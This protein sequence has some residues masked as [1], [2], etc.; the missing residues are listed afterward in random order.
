MSDGGF[1]L[2][3]AAVASLFDA[4]TLVV[5]EVAPRSGGLALPAD[6]AIVGLKSPKGADGSRKLSTMAGLGYYLKVISREVR[7]ADVVH[8]PLPGDISLLGFVVALAFRKR[9]IGRYGSSWVLT[10]QTTA[11][12][13][14]TRWFMRL[15]AGGRNVMLATGIGSAPPAPRMRWIFSTA[16]SKA[17]VASIRPD[18]DR[19]LA[20]PP[21][22][23]YIGRLSSEK[24]VR[25]L[26]QAMAK[27]RESGM[28]NMPHLTLLGD[29]PDRDRL[30]RETQALAI[31][32]H[33]TFAGYQNRA[34]L[35]AYLRGADLCVQPS[36]T[37]GFSKAWLDALVHGVPVVSSRVGAAA[38]VIGDS[39]GRGWLVPPGNVDALANAI[40]SALSRDDAWPVLRR[41]CQAAAQD[42][43][44][45][46]WAQEIGAICAE[47]WGGTLAGGKLRV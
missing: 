12:Q 45:E 37:E 34:S 2:Q 19:A 14:V 9:V 13:R 43:T 31:Q 32:G 15:S 47:Q 35:S 46:A 1:P 3:M 41:R 28:A 21:R 25:Y 24:G 11:A 39:G 30:E 36:L 17:D 38:A 40:R 20:D 42:W 27:L 23:V 26:L 7:K 8:V 33:V 10:R 4:T 5:V 22:L 16:L 18:L 6:A 29:G 44:L